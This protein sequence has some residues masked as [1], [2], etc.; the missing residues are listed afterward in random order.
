MKVAITATAAAAAAAAPWP[1]SIRPSS[2][3][4]SGWVVSA[5]AEN[6]TEEQFKERTRVVAPKW[7]GLGWN[8][9]AGEGIRLIGY[10][11]RS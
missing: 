5:S 1:P 10:R 8:S 9:T 7:R 4:P 2:P 11:E 3:G 6:K